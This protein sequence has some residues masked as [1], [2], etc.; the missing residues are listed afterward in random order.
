MAITL[1]MIERCQCTDYAVFMKTIA[2]VG[3]CKPGA[4]DAADLRVPCLR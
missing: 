3:T 1:E 2:P 4:V